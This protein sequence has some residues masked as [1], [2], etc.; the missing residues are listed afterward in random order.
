MFVKKSLAGAV[1]ALGLAGSAVAATSA[2]TIDSNNSAAQFTVRH[3]GISNVQGDFTKIS[4]SVN[5]DD[6]DVSKSSVNATVDVT[7][8]D[9]RVTMRD[10]DLKSEKFFNVAQ[11]PAMTFQSTKIEKSGDGS[12]K[13]TGNLT[14]R[15]VTKV[16]TFDVAGPT[17]A[18]N[19]NGTMRRGAE[20]TTKIDRRDFG[21]T[22]DEGIVGDEV[23]ITLDIEMTQPGTGGTPAPVAP[24]SKAAQG[25][26]R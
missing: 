2:W 9:T 25:P 13:M 5:L 15:G 3:L 17:P 18:V 19:Q 8:I 22:A 11:F 20:A 21:M 10:N 23:T 16:V 14:L 6:A 26:G 1:L 24:G 4:G 12:A 7:S